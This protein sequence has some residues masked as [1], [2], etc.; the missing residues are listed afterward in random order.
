M[1]KT[2]IILAALLISAT[3]FA[4]NSAGDYFEGYTRTITYDRMIPPYGLQVTFE[5]T[6][7]VIF[8]A[9]II[10]VDLGSNNLIA[11]KASGAENV[12]RVKAA[13]RGFESE[14]NL[15]VITGD[16]S[17]Y[18]YNIRYADEPEKLSVEMKDF[19]HD[20]EAVN[21]P[22]NALEVYLTEL[23]NESPR[24]VNLIN[25][26]IYRN[27]R[28]HVKHIGSKRFGIQ[29][30][31][32][33]I[34]SNDGL[35]YLHTQ[36]K[37]ESNVPFDVD[38]VRIKIVD[39]QVAKRTAIQETVIYPIRAYNYVEQVR[40]KKTERTVFTIDKITIPDDKQMVIELFEK[41]GGRHQ[42]FIIE[43]ADIVRARVIDE[44][45]E[46][47]GRQRVYSISPSR[48]KSARSELKIK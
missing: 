31:L 3:A 37:N 38:F 32:K 44:L 2:A 15:A 1:K 42:E 5:K 9:P 7:H 36:I 34:Y 39:K 40:G 46:Q 27:D 33:G 18:T 8:P 26:S 23:A 21:R 16:G 12:L 29:Y 6:V 13:V 30:L 35:L 28:R 19:M 41:N 24:L 14:T 4:Q 20:G 25:R 45:L 43:N 22:N 17:F 10:Y 11:G 48:D 47:R